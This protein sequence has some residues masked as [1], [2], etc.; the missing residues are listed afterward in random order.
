[1]SLIDNMA[2]IKRRDGR[3]IFVGEGLII[4]ISKIYEFQL[5]EYFS[6]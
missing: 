3:G 4:E 2:L 6:K 5:L 1:M